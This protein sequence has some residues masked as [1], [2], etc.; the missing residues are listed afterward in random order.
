MAMAGAVIGLRVPD[1]QIENIETTG[2]TLPGFGD[3]WLEMVN[4]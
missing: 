1:L 2:K 4:S 3:M